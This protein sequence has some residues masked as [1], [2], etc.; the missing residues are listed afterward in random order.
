[1]KTKKTIDWEALDRMGS[2]PPK[3]IPKPTKQGP[4]PGRP[5]GDDPWRPVTLSLPTGL[6]TKAK[7][8][9]EREGKKVSNV[10]AELL[11]A[12]LEK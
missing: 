10:V 2:K 11:T 9:A 4:G 3:K 8:R 1:M 12:W 6:Y 5:A 7:A